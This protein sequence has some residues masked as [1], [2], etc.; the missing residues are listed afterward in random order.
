MNKRIKSKKSKDEKLDKLL[1]RLP[2][3]AFK[4]GAPFILIYL[5]IFRGGLS[6]NQT[7]W[8]AF[9]DFIGGVMGVVIGLLTLMV[10]GK[11]YMTQKK[12]L[13]ATLEELRLNRAEQINAT[14]ELT[15]QNEIAERREITNGLMQAAKNV[16]HELKREAE[17]TRVEI[18]GVGGAPNQRV[19]LFQLIQRINEREHGYN[20]EEV[21]AYPIDL[22]NFLILYLQLSRCFLRDYRLNDG[23]TVNPL[24]IS[25]QMYWIRIYDALDGIGVDMHE[26]IHQ[27]FNLI[28]EIQ[29]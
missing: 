23:Q 26:D 15:R 10:L 14:R 11:A 2:W 12:E 20:R 25:L 9:G 28:R 27:A 13:S 16:H 8:G 4:I 5:I 1:N 7:D 6:S 24:I 18:I 21:N 19:N 22:F 3:T 29:Q 17:I